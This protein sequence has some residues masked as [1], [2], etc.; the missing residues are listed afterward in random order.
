MDPVIKAKLPGETAQLWKRPFLAGWLKIGTRLTLCFALIAVLMLAAYVVALVQFRTVR[1]QAQRLHS[2]DQ[3]LAKL[4][5][6]HVALL[7]LRDRLDALADDG[8]ASRFNAE[9]GPL[10]TALLRDV[11]QAEQSFEASP[12]DVARDPTVIPTLATVGSA[13]SSQVETLTS[14]ATLGDWRA[15]HLRSNSQLRDLSRLTGS[16]I[17]RVG[18]QVD[19]E[20]A[21]TLHNIERVQRRIF[22]TLPVTGILTLLIAGILGLTVTRSITQPLHELGRGAKALAVGELDYRVSVEGKDELATLSTTFNYAI[23]EL[24]NL[25]GAL[26]RREA[27][28]RSLIEHS[29]DLIA[30]LERGGMIRFASPSSYRIA[31]FFP[32]ELEGKSI[33]E[34]V[35][36]DDSSILQNIL[37][38]DT[39]TT[40]RGFEFRFRHS[41]GSFRVLEAIA[42]NRLS[43]PAV[44]GIVIN[45]RDITER[46]A[47]EEA[48]RENEE[49]FRKVLETAEVGIATLDQEGRIRFCNRAGLALFGLT[50][51]QVLGKS[52]EFITPPTL[53]ED[54]SVCTP[55]DQLAARAIATGKEIRGIVQRVYREAFRDW[56]WVLASAQPILKSDGSL[57]EVIVT[58]TDITPLKDAEEAVRQSEAEF[59]TIFDNAAMG[60]ALADVSG[61]LVRVNPAFQR[62]LGY[63]AH[64][65]EQMTFL[66]ITHPADVASSSS[67]YKELIEGKRDRYR[68][69]K[70][71]VRKG[72]EL[73]WTWLSTSAMRLPDRQLQYCVSMI[74]DI[75]QQELAEQSLYEL[76]TR[77]LRIQEE[78][79]RRIA[80]EVHDS[81]SQELAALAMNLGALRKSPEALSPKIRK[82]LAECLSILSSVSRQIR[83]FSYLLHPPLIDE[84]G[85]WAALRVF[86]EEFRNRSGLKVGLQIDRNLEGH[87]LHPT[88]EMT[89]FRF[90]QEGLANVHKH[91]GSKT[92]SVQVQLQDHCIRASIADKGRG[93]QPAVL[94][95]INS[96]TGRGVGVG[97]PG[98]KERVRQLGGHLEI[99]SDLQGTVVVAMVPVNYPENPLVKAD[100]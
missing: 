84:F 80:R 56:R 5:R 2:V 39:G 85:L 24:S 26:A 96:A 66:D 62:L 83:T 57:Y 6:V 78:E 65:L 63:S 49:R 53:R 22:I 1:E 11:E 21:R 60:I 89:L 77:M 61:R 87:R 100:R 88:C 16:L 92:V 25:Y 10:R 3:Q 74:E 13:V 81:T 51:E 86:I 9:A 76:S 45:A 33:F 72:G 23:E 55:D 35:E 64:E 27:Q 15:V 34:F 46:K 19:E 12:S 71:Y 31:G 36:H 95:E 20:Q 37:S 50:L 73:C 79:Q 8:D 41:N 17:E 97:I 67:L 29:S 69:K 28:F 32:V 93:I 30:V 94:K 91:A 7:Q 42:N 43:E 4:Q 98:M 75:T 40:S 58:F 70:R 48:L 47:A 90:V 82:K 59:R 38:G 14:L 54:G 99:Q 52:S 18:A 68:I 44:S